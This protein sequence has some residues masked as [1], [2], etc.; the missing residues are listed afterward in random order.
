VSS[1]FSCMTGANHLF[2]FALQFAVAS[3]ATVIATSSSNDKLA[4]AKKLGA[5]HLINYK[6]KPDWDQEVLKIVGID[7]I[8]AICRLANIIPDERYWCRPCG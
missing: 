1:H 8:T 2:S 7:S 3:G 4:I 6:E 5:K